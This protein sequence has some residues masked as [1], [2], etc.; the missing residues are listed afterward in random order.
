MVSP[1][2]V[3][4]TELTSIACG[5]G[6]YDYFYD[7]TDNSFPKRILG[8]ATPQ[9]AKRPG[10]TMLCLIVIYVASVSKMIRKEISSERSRTRCAALFSQHSDFRIG[11]HVTLLKLAEGEVKRHANAMVWETCANQCHIFSRRQRKHSYTIWLT[12]DSS[13]DHTR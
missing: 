8:L 7:E 12:R 4:K 5:Q 6:N 3:W 2:T 10:R 11:P 1:T 13:I 9:Q